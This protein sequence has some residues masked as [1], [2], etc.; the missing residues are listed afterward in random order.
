[1]RYFL[2]LLMLLFTPAMAAETPHEVVVKGQK[3]RLQVFAWRD[4]MP[5]VGGDGSGSPLML[6]PSLVDTAGKP[7]DGVAFSEIVASFRGQDWRAKVADGT[8]RG[9]PRWPT[10]QNELSVR[11]HY[12]YKGTEGWI[13][14][15]KPTGIGR[16]E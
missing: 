13:R 9:G 7:L 1:M 11:A 2:L 5:Q 12:T 10:G 4:F 16:T 8:A 3:L 15:A 6:T 14:L